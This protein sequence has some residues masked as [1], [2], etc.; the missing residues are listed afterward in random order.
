MLVVKCFQHP[1]RLAAAKC[2]RC[3][4]SFCRECVTEHG[5]QFRCAACL[6][7]D[8]GGVVGAK[9]RQGRLVLVAMAFGA[10]LGSWL[11][12]TTVG[13]WLEEITMPAARKTAA[14]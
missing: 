8:A 14:K 12:F 3:G 10:V 13:W 9:K 7:L 6:R 2:L 5:G 1:D 4:K 11:L